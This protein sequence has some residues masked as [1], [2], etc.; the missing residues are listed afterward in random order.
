MIVLKKGGTNNAY[1]QATF[2]YEMHLYIYKKE[3][4]MSKTL[5]GTYSPI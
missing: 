1:V 2:L 3:M 4:I 5:K